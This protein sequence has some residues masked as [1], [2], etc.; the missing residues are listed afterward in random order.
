[1]LYLFIFILSGCT[2]IS[3]NIL[4]LVKSTSSNYMQSWQLI[5]T[6]YTIGLIHV[7]C[8]WLNTNNSD[9]HDRNYHCKNKIIFIY[10]RVLE[11]WRSH[12]RKK[13]HCFKLSGKR[14]VY[15][16]RN[17]YTI[18]LDTLDFK[19][20]TTVYMPLVRFMNSDVPKYGISLDAS[21]S[22]DKN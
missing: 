3:Y 14:I 16:L 1:M 22:P 5:L 19:H 15:G 13:L 7:L 21:A 12:W 4:C 8:A 11:K 18:V 10:F 9:I 20:S 6:N 2:H 17:V